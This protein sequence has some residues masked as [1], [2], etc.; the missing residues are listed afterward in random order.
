MLQF[1]DLRTVKISVEHTNVKA[2]NIT[3]NQTLT[4][5]EFL[6]FFP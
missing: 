5:R 2:A 4:P 1:T 3:L 6:N